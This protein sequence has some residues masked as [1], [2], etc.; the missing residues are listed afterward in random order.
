[1]SNFR[2]AKVACKL[3]NLLHF[4]KITADFA[5]P[6]R[7]DIDWDREKLPTIYEKRTET[8]GGVPMTGKCAE[9]GSPD[10]AF[11]CSI[12]YTSY[13]FTF[14]CSKDHQKKDWN[15]HKRECK[16]LP[17][18]LEPTEVA[19][20]TKDKIKAMNPVRF[21]ECFKEGESVVIMH[22]ASDK[23]LYVRPARPDDNS[24]ENLMK[25][26]REFSKTAA[27]TSKKPEI[28]STILA[29]FEGGYQRA[30]VMDYETSPDSNDLLVFFIDIGVIKKVPASNL[31]DLNFKFRL[32]ER[33]TFKVILESVINESN[34]H[35]K[36]H[37]ET[38]CLDQVELKVESIRGEI[39]R[40]VVLRNGNSGDTVNEE[41][42]K[43]TTMIEPSMLD[44]RIFFDVS[45]RT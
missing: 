7:N 19:E 35:V 8:E 16:R 34:P 18:L 27:K 37:L 3:V 26:L 22:V 15:C 5:T 13:A 29:P 10:A 41:V 17:I 20:A 2:H 38:L 30:Q 11:V 28:N 42:Q 9:C 12:C 25:D 44:E 43:I 23:V 36:K 6:L 32:R 33:Q 40:F 21:A 4:K 24:F 45:Q 1:M 14:Y 31:K 39:D